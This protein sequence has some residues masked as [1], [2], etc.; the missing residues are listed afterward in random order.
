MLRTKD[1]KSEIKSVK[2]GI[3]KMRVVNFLMS[4]ATF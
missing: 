4:V 3:R 1:R 2:A